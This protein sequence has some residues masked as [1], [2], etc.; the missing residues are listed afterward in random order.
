MTRSDETTATANEQDCA[1]R[2]SR[3]FP[4]AKAVRIPVQITALRTGNTWLREATVVEFGCA[5]HAIFLSTLPLEFDDRVR[6]ERDQHGGTAEATV[7]AVQYHEGHKAVAV[8][9]V[10]GP[11]AWVTQP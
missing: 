7:I 11:C 10:G 8:R 2:L 5:E 3:F 4:R 6:M 9:F 1:E